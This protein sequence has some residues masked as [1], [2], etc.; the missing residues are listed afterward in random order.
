MAV[1]GIL[2]VVDAGRKSVGRL[3]VSFVVSKSVDTT[4]S[5]SSV[6]VALVA[7][8]Q[9]EE[10]IATFIALPGAESVSDICVACPD[11][12]EL[13]DRGYVGLRSVPFEP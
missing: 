12:F 6:T 2:A 13:D 11:D 3:V 5:S 4:L 1:D 9:V 10:L 8:D 7:E